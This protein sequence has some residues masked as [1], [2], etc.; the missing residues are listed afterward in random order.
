MN[1]FSQKTK[2]FG[3]DIS[4]LSLKIA[5]IEKKGRNLKLV[6][7]GDC[8]V[9]KGVI[10]EGQIQDEDALVK[11]I[12]QGLGSVKGKE[13]KTKKVACC[14]PEEKSFLD[15]LH[16]P[17]LPAEEIANAV[18]FEA[19]NHIPIPLSDVYFDFELIKSLNRNGVVQKQGSQKQLEVLIAA[20]PK[21][22][23]DSYLSVL[24][25]AGLHPVA[26]E[27]E[28]LSIVR[29]LVKQVSTKPFLIIDFGASRTSFIIFSGR[30]IGFTST[31]PVSSQE[32]TSVVAK[33][34]SIT[35]KKAEKIKQ[36]Q[37][38]QGDKA[39]FDSMVPVLTDLTQQI[40]NHLDYYKSHVPQAQAASGNNK[41]ERILLCGGGAQLRGLDDFLTSTFK[42]KVEM[43]DLW[44]NLA[45]PDQKDFPEMP[46][47]KFFGYSTAFGL[48]LRGRC[49]RDI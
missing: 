21:N 14:L 31:I 33:A 5:N 12:K 30:S 25:K 37:G 18:R 26:L 39:L 16:L 17:V 24:K 10:K 45:K 40:K 22:I 46:T 23:V 36:E 20:T 8:P 49:C 42:I 1:L 9:P 15:I 11:A 3:L 34:M 43:A 47:E 32:L 4:D 13:I 19:E 6:S 7:F 38:L 44:A 27:V 28:P 2:S 29:T 41:M 35:P 48:A